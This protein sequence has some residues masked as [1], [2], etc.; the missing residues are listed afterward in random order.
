ME[1]D[2]AAERVTL[3]LVAEEAGVSLSTIS[4]VLNGRADVSAATRARVEELLHERG[5]AR[6]GARAQR[7]G[8]FIELVF[9]EL[10]S[11]W[12]MELIDGV[13]NV[14]KE[15]GLSVVLTVS[16]S[17]HSPAPD[18]IEGVMRRRPVGVVLVFSD[19][20]PEYRERLRSRAIPFV[21]VDPAGDPSPD[22]PSVGS[23]NWSGG[24]LATRH[25][26]ELGHRRIAAITGPDDMMCSLAR[27]DGYRSAMNSAGLEIRPEWIR[28]GDFHVTGGRDR[29]TELLALPER[30]TAIFAGS[31]LQALGAMDAARA[32]ALRVPEDVSIVGYD[33]IPLA[34]W[35]TPRL[36]TVLQPLKRMGEEAARLAIRLSEE[37]PP[38]TPRMDLATSLVVRD[39]T[40]APAA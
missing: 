30:P 7:K 12:S 21:I 4:K 27:V 24:L 1:T 20:A 33:D 16:G 26:I 2:A 39:S 29:A 18:W 9:H 8:E 11:I 13:E 25:L 37:T 23:A 15:H 22:A 32:L 34:R 5:Y 10:E 38:T 19:L 17:R 36:T 3:A 6:R 40:A 28:F 35:V 31:D 14:A